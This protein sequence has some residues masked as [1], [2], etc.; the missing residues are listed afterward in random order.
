MAR[1]VKMY[2]C[3]GYTG[4][5]LQDIG[6]YFGIGGSGISQ[7]SRRISQKIDNDKKL[8]IKIEKIEK[9]LKKLMMK[10][11]TTIYK[12]ERITICQNTESF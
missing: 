2:L 3:Q 8:K 4:E 5:K 6:K 9:K 10:T 12:W 11:L 7:A 1:N